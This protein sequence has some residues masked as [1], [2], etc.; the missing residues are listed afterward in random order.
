VTKL[1]G[2]TT[3]LILAAALGGCRTADMGVVQRAYYAGDHDRALERLEEYE[4]KDSSNAQ[5]WELEK[6]IVHI[7]AGDLDLALENLRSV[8]EELVEAADKREHRKLLR[9]AKSLLTDDNALAYKLRDYEHQLVYALLAALEAVHGGDDAQAYSLQGLTLAL[10]IQSKVAEDTVSLFASIDEYRDVNGDNPKDAYRLVGFG[11][12]I[13]ASLLE[14][15]PTRADEAERAY[16]RAFQLS[17]DYPYVEQ[18]LARVRGEVR[19]EAGTGVLYVLTLTGRGPLLEETIL[20][21]PAEAALLIAKQIWAHDQ[22][23]ETFPIV[24]GIR[25]PE[26]RFATENP[27]DVHVAVDGAPAGITGTLTDI[28]KTA[29]IEFAAMH[30]TIVARAILRRAIKLAA[31]EVIR[32]NVEDPRDG[33]QYAWQ[34]LLIDIGVA[35]WSSAEQADLRSW[36]LLPARLQVLRIELPPGEHTIQLQAGSEA[37]QAVGRVIERKT[38]IQ[39][40]Y[41]TYMIAAMPTIIE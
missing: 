29:E 39:A 9:G 11:D 23:Q 16:V 34:D 25:I 8:R 27:T 13:R 22:H 4:R 26:L 41:N 38:R 20:D 14:E 35:I 6:S 5:R 15:S 21:H 33:G 7:A 31:G 17:P 32:H 40:G 2:A 28:E 18:D 12:F 30:S 10:E 19:S 3:V 36:S 24:T 1:T 37:G